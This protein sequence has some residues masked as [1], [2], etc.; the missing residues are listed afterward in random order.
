M[1]CDDQARFDPRHVIV[2]GYAGCALGLSKTWTQMCGCWANGLE[3]VQS[4][5]SL[6]LKPPDDCYC[7][8]WGV[9]G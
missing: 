7:A 9:E 2:C 6:A 8:S 4:V 5:A 1:A 3:T